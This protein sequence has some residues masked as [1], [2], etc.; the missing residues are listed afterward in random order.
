MFEITRLSDAQ[1][2]LCKRTISSNTFFMLVGDALI[3]R[4]TLS[5]VRM[6]DGEVALFDYCLGLRTNPWDAIKLD[7]MGVA[8]ITKPLLLSRLQKAATSCTYFAPSISGIWR[9]DY[10]NYTPFHERT[11]YVDNFFVN[12]WSEEMITQLFLEAKHVLLIHRNAETAD[13]M[14][15]RAK[16][17]LGVKVT[18]IKMNSWQESEDVI[19][20]AIC[21]DAPL[22]LFSGGPACKYI[23]LEIAFYNKVVLDIGNSIDRWTFPSLAHINE[24]DF[25]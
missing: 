13:A 18:F 11:Q 16:Y 19:R 1:K 7:N 24:K 20:R 2:E 6:G 3:R 8:G 17:G 25:K 4:K 5:V 23:G 12:A 15:I 14:Q 10:D 9:K 22:V 21:V